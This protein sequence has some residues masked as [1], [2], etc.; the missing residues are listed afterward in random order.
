MLLKGQVALVTGSARG[1][2]RAIAL[3]LAK[4][5]ADIALADRNDELLEG[6][7]KE[8]EGLGRRALPMKTD[9]LVQEQIESAV[10]KTAD[11]LGRLDILVNCAGN[12]ILK[13]FLET[14]VEQFRQQMD[15]HFMA[16]VIACKAAIPIMQKQGRGK[17][18]SMS[19]ISGTVGYSHHSAYS[20][21]KGSIIRFSEAIAQELK[22][23]HINVNCIAPNAVD[24]RLFDEW[25]E[26]TGTRLD[27][28][29]WIQPEEIGDLV[30]YL[31]SPS[32]RSITGET[33]VLQ[34]IYPS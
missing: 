29:E 15:L 21:A 7:A 9:V 2:G 6:T 22:P 12:I 1:I 18:I 11:T 32:A 34:G 3:A 10:Y 8:I 33:I 20:P 16:T 17:I 31:C 13:P 23:D 4:A 28:S 26:E 25:I 30:V 24:T 5:G 27:R 14:S 19:S